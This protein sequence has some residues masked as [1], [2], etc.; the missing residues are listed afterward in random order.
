MNNIKTPFAV[1]AIIVILFLAAVGGS[2]AVIL[3]PFVHKPVHEPVTI[4]LNKNNVKWWELKEGDSI[5]WSHGE[6]IT[7]SMSGEIEFVHEVPQDTIWGLINFKPLVLITDGDTV[8]YWFGDTVRFQSCKQQ[9]ASKWSDAKAHRD[10]MV[11]TADNPLIASSSTDVQLGGT[12]MV[13]D[14]M[15]TGTWGG[16]IFIGDEYEKYEKLSER[17]KYIVDS[18]KEEGIPRLQQSYM[19][20]EP[21][22]MKQGKKVEWFWDILEQQITMYQYVFWNNGK[23]HGYELLKSFE[24]K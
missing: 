11:I 6:I 10:E 9:L 7:D 19:T 23:G 18:L 22:Y 21:I 15:I 17:G 4:V 12:V 14:N 8:R 5:W 3:F 16:K 2:I 13:V 24:V 20:Y 1:R